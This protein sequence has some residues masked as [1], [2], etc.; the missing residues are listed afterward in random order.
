MNRRLQIRVFFCE[1]YITTKYQFFQVSFVINKYL[2][3]KKNE[4]KPSH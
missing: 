1:F 4:R 3:L 2:M